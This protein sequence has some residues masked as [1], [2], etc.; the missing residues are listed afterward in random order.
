MRKT[1]HEYY[2]SRGLST[3]KYEAMCTFT[4]WDILHFYCFDPHL[5]VNTFQVSISK[6]LCVSK[7]SNIKTA[8]SL[9]LHPLPHAPLC[10][11][12]WHCDS[13]VIICIIFYSS[14]FFVLLVL[15]L[16]HLSCSSFLSNL[17][18]CH[19]MPLFICHAFL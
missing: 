5:Y 14:L 10:F 15:L 16:K 9:S 11:G 19:P 17:Y 12:Q 7:L 13:P 2:S 3:R 18:F 1:H 6:S 8:Y 4:V